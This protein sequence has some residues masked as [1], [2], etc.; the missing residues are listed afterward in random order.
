MCHEVGLGLEAPIKNLTLKYH[1]IIR[2]SKLSK[3]VSTLK[4]EGLLGDNSPWAF[5]TMIHF[6]MEV[7]HLGKIIIRYGA[8][9]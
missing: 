8:H 3:M 6:Y 2:L 1:Q 9:K 5:S 4:A 7:V